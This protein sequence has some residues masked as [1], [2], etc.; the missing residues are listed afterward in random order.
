MLHTVLLQC[1]PTLTSQGFVCCLYPDS[2]TTQG[3]PASTPTPSVFWVTQMTTQTHPHI[4]FVG[5]RLSH[6]LSFLS[7]HED[8]ED[9][10]WVSGPSTFGVSGVTVALSY[11]LTTAPTRHSTAT[12][13]NGLAHLPASFAKHPTRLWHSSSVVLFNPRIWVGDFWKA[14]FQVDHCLANLPTIIVQLPHT[15]G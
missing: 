10:P 2:S 5:V 15:P 3:F 6:F 7:S 8:R 9:C 4:I 12:C 1:C 14:Q 11:H 13:Y